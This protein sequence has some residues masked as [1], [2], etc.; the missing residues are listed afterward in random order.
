MKYI[1]LSFLFISTSLS[2]TE[3]EP[4]PVFILVGQ[5]NMV[6]KRSLISKLPKHL[7]PAQ[8][9]AL[10]YHSKKGWKALK[11][12]ETEKQGFGPEI[13]FAYEMQKLMQTQIGIIKFSIGGTNLHTQW[14]RNNP[15]SLYHKTIN[16]YKKA[17][18]EK[19]IKVLGIIWVHGGADAKRKKDAIAYEK[20]FRKLITNF[21]EDC[22]APE[23]K[24]LCGRCGTSPTPEAD[25]KV[26]PYIDIVREAQDKLKY[27]FYKSVDLDHISTG[28]D[29]V[30]F[31][32][33]GMVK[34][35]ELYAEEMFKLIQDQK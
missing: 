9:D 1:L 29:N 17:T 35:G 34:T 3:K 23:L 26:K 14:N 5:S 8:K 28:P 24:V 4:L 25:R 33:K 2:A 7:T 15:K 19:N 11:P 31:D 12:S 10:F 6:G 13:S 30:H 20:N 21:Q 32:T 16:L 22:N 18:K 27:K